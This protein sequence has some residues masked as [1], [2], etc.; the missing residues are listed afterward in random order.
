MYGDPCDGDALP[1]GDSD[2]QYVLY[3]GNQHPARL[4]IVVLLYFLQ[5]RCHK[6]AV[7]VMV[8]SQKYSSP[9]SLTLTHLSYAANLS[10]ATIQRAPMHTILKTH[11]N[12]ISE[13]KLRSNEL[14]GG[15]NAYG[16]AWG[17][18]QL[19]TLQCGQLRSQRLTD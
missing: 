6:Y 13:L 15:V 14:S 5:V 8:L 16:V 10:S 4:L 11:I 2:T 9:Y 12:E 17:K 19:G 7:A 3:C 18:S 1:G